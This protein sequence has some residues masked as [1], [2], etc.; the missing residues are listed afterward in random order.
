MLR[1]I[2][3]D[4]PASVNETYLEHLF[5]A[6]R[7]SLKLLVSGLAC[8]IHAIVPCLFTATAKNTVIHLND[9]LVNNR[10]KQTP[11]RHAAVN[12]RKT[13]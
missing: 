10:H 5:Q 11:L 3:L 1:K 4:H 13:S 2:F 7:F 8:F 9:I 12:S 6:G